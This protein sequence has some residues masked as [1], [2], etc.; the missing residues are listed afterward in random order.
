MVFDILFWVF[1]VISVINTAHFGLYLI[2]A[3]YYDILRFRKD[4]QPKKRSRTPK[5]LVSILIPAHDEE[6]SI[7][8]SLDSVRKSSYRK[9][10]VIVIDDAST[11][12]TRAI[13]RDYIKRYPKMNLKLM[14]KRTNVGKAA[15]MNHGLRNGMHGELVMTLDADSLIDKKSVANAV[16]YFDDPKIVG[17]AANVQVID[18][19]TILGLLQKFEYMIGYRSKKFFTVTNSEFIIGGVASTY[20]ASTLKKVGFYDDDIITEDIALSLKIVSQGNKEHRVVYGVNVLA[21]TEGVLNFNALLRQRYRWKMGNLQSIFKYRHL[22]ADRSGKHSIMLTWYRIPMA[23]LGEIL[24]LLEPFVIIYVL[25]ICLQLASL[26]MIMGA[27]MVITVYLLWNVLHDEHMDVKKKLQLSSYAP[28]MYFIMYIMN[29]V[30]LIAVV[31][32]LYN[33]R[34]VLRI[35]KTKSTWK[36]PERQVNIPSNI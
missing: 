35:V 13:V 18:M 8:R 26:G 14:Y 21:M 12:K 4:A 16:E 29:V 15:A 7:V 32:C 31:R 22:F 11:D 24:V 30:Q 25:Y 36:S 6:L 28:V 9:L 19:T 20:R 1:I 27:Y 33:Y 23:F 5:P 2:G 3:N 34:K 10:E 17:V